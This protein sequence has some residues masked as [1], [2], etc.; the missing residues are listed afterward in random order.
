M[1]IKFS[2]LKKII[3]RIK[4]F[5]S[6]KNYSKTP[7]NKSENLQLRSIKLGDE[8]KFFRIPE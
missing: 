8:T 2:F 3:N 5:K 7:P 4:I 6:G 1:Q